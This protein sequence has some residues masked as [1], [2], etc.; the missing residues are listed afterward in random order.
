MKDVALICIFLIFVFSCSKKEPVT[1]SVILK[2]PGT[3]ETRNF[4][5]VTNPSISSDDMRFIMPYVDE[6]IADSHERGDYKI[7]MKLVDTMDRGELKEVAKLVLKYKCE[8]KSQDILESLFSHDGK[9]L[10]ILRVRQTIG[11]GNLKY[12]EVA[13]KKISEEYE[14]CEDNDCY[15]FVMVDYYDSEGNRIGGYEYKAELRQ[16][17]VYYSNFHLPDDV[18][19]YKVWVTK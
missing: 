1:L 7:N 3:G 4:P 9:Y 10:K 18:Y 13:I 5:C 2:D 19:S 11:P 16:N 15:D 6:V 17:D 14:K 12:L 8:H